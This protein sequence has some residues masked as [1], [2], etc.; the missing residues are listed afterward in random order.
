M[1]VRIPNNSFCNEL[2]KQFGKPIVTTSINR[3]GEQPMNDPVQMKSE[4]SS[5]VDL[6][7]DAGTLQKSGGSTIYK[8]I[9]NKIIILRK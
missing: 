3:T 9:D 1:G 8:F 6:I 2:S 5:N 7:I 4:F